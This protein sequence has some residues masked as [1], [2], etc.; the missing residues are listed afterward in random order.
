MTSAAMYICIDLLHWIKEIISFSNINQQVANENVSF[1]SS[2]IEEKL[3]PKITVQKHY[4]KFHRLVCF[5]LDE[6]KVSFY[7][8]EYSQ[9]IY[10]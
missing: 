7:E 8:Y 5:V 9:I 10:I 1:I 2:S 6:W 3:I 4:S